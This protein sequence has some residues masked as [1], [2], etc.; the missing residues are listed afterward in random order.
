MKAS[1]FASLLFPA[2]LFPALLLAQQPQ[3]NPQLGRELAKLNPDHPP[4]S[5]PTPDSAQALPENYELSLSIADKD[6]K[7]TEVS[8]V[9]A[10]SKFNVSPGQP[11]LRFSGD[12]KIE[13]S[14]IMVVAY[15]LEWEIP[16]DMGGRGLQFKPASVHGS[17]RLKL[18]E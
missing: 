9:V 5:A 6:A 4:Q 17:V 14:G 11:S 1:I 18:G 15:Q 12:L 16:V 10:S 8:V 7:P 3:P 2:L 13:D